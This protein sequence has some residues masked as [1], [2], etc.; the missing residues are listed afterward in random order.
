MADT[1]TQ[2]LHARADDDNLAIT[3]DGGTWS[4]REYIADAQR[5]AAT[6]LAAADTGRP[7]H[8]GV[9]LG[10]T[11]DMLIAL[12]AGALGG[13]VTVGVNN[14]RRGDGLAADIKRAD[15]QILITD[16]E[17]RPLLDGLDLP[18]V[19][20][21]DTSSSQWADL[22]ADATDL[23]PHSIPTAT[24]TFM[25]IFTSGTSGNPKPVQFAHMMIPFAGPV[26][27]DKYSVGPGDVCYLSMPLFH[28]AALMGGYCVA[29]CGGAAMAPAKFSASTFLSDIRRYNATY[30][31]YV[32][33]PLAYI[34]ATPEQADDADNSLRVAFGNEATDRDIDEF[35]RRF[36]CT[37]WDGF[38]STELAIIITREPGTPHGSIG[39]GF[40]NV[41]VY[42]SATGIECPRAEFDAN[43]ALANADEAIGELVN[44]DGG[45]MFMG[46]YNDAGATQERLRDGKYWSGDLAYKDADD[47][48]YLAGRTGDWM[49]VDGENLA[50]GPIERILL[51]IP[52]INRVAVYAVP[53]EHVGDAI[54][55]A[56]VLQ[57]DADFDPDHFAAQLADQA[58]LSPKAWPRF[59]RIADDLPTTA[60]NKILKRALKTEGVTAGDGTLWVREPRSRTY[61]SA[62]T[63]G[64][65]A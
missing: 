53:D 12:A 17:H 64:N 8:V 65:P 28:S 7:M 55:A 31:N 24:D 41:A 54:M 57:D 9:L 56:V 61:R 1:V 14:T 59:V 50:A 60:T 26:L 15:C 27:V 45:G 16:A 37:V 46:Y 49:R 21:F 48:I 34:L 2:L 23:T 32:G 63:A 20:I 10:N 6:V 52:E 18:D 51:R 39:K 58:D 11:P 13:Y 3:Y 30:M 33:K 47:W 35:S 42:N 43:G 36:G 40:P 29:L 5:M 62:V 44:I 4:W 22:L 19:T 38:G 25:L